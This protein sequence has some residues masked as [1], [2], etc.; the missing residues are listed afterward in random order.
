MLEGFAFLGWSRLLDVILLRVESNVC[1]WDASPPKIPRQKGPC[2]AFREGSVE[3]KQF[4][5]R[6]QKEWAPN[7]GRWPFS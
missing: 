3:A 2:M 7:P 4:A 5:S 6:H 1:T